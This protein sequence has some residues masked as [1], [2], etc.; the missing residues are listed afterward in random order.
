MKLFCRFMTLSEIHRKLCYRNRESE[1]I[2]RN[3]R[4]KVTW[5]WREYSEAYTLKS[6]PNLP[7]GGVVGGQ[8]VLLRFAMKCR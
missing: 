1:I 7:I 6:K 8:G 3:R 4:E 2:I 5:V